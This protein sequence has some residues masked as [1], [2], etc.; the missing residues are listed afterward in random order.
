MAYS[1]KEKKK[2]MEEFVKMTE[3][4]ELRALSKYSLEHP[5][6]PIQYNRMMFLARKYKIKG[7]KIPNV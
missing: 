6:T 4:A 3:L 5:L 7:G 1:I 2:L